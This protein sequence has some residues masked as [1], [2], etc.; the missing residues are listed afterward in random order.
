MNTQIGRMNI[1]EIA[2]QHIR[3]LKQSAEPN[4]NGGEVFVDELCSKLRAITKGYQQKFKTQD[5]EVKFKR[6]FMLA[7]A[8]SG[9]TND[10]AVKPGLHYYRNNSEW[11]PTPAEF[12]DACQNA[13][14]SGF[15]EPH[16]AFIEYC[17]HFNNPRHKWSHA[18]V[19][20]AAISSGQSFDIQRL[21]E[22][23]S[24]PIYNRAYEILKRRVI[25]GEE[26]E[27]PISKALPKE[28]QVVVSREESKKKM[29]EILASY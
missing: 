26:L 11:M 19:R 20:L 23:Q 12:I 21:P 2:M 8:E 22:D 4:L 16:R 10:D 6:Q 9:L 1:E 27:V 3:E 7:L 13:T 18:A 24:F 5:Q 28:V 29:K 15:P 25:L 17:M 14:V